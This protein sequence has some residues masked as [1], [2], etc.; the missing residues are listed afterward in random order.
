MA[1]RTFILSAVSALALSGCAVGPDRVSPSPPSPSATSGPFLS[2]QNDIVTAN[3]LPQD[4]WRLYEDPVLDGLVADALGANTDIRQAV[5]RMDRARAALRGAR[6]DRL[7]TVGL[8]A[9][10]AYSRTPEFETPPGADRTGTGI[11]LGADVSYEVDLFGRV[12]GQISASRNDLA[13]AQADADAVRVMVVADTTLAYANAASA[14][15]RIDVA[16]SIVALLDDSLRLTRRRHE[17]GMADG[18]AVARIQSLRDQRA[19]TIPEIEAQRSAA[20]F[21]LATLTGR[22]PAELPTISGERSIPLEIAAPLPVGDGTQLLARRPDVRAAEQRLL[23]DTDRIGVAR[24]DLYPRIT[25]GGSVGSSASSVSNLFSGGPLGFI[26]GPLIDW[27]FPNREPVFARIDA[28]KADARASLAAF[29]GAILNALQETET[30]LSRYAGAIERRRSLEQAMRAANKAARI[31]RAQNR[32]GVIDSLDLLD[33]ERTLAETRAELADQD[34]LVSSRQ[35]DLFRALGGS[36]SAER[37]T[38]S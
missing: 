16:R 29:D 6:S 18:L 9:S 13:A 2:A 20:L 8:T 12:S 21:A 26:L 35:I 36:W 10:A 4:W 31:T 32:E 17:V 23:A 24:A 33:A 37:E 30:A 19:A 1:Y 22:T 25:L 5:A 38:A 27:V 7:P 14:A 15:A 28:A 3:P 11:S 34:A